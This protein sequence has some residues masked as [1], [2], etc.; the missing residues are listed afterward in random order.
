MDVKETECF[1]F[2]SGEA[3]YVVLST[4]A[5]YSTWI[6]DSHYETNKKHPDT[7]TAVPTLPIYV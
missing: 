7:D 2:S 5:K 3:Y 6:H 4:W 1:T